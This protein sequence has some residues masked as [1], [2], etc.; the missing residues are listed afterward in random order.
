MKT[1]TV[2]LLLSCI[3]ILFGVSSSNGQEA[4]AL[5]EKNGF[6]DIQLTSEVSQYD[7]LTFKKK[8]SD[9][10]FPDAQL[11]TAKAGHYQEV[12]GIRIQK[13]EVKVYTG[14][15]YE[16]VVIADKDPNFYN[17]LERKYG[18]GKYSVKNN[19]YNWS[20]KNISLT[21][22]SLSKSKVILTYFSHI[23]KKKVK[24]DQKKKVKDIA[25]DF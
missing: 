20:G 7:G 15:I 6:Q 19:S 24:E 23:V 1:A 10:A 2:T 14:L 8:L 17:G 9:K 11:F 16:I 21:F 25:D 22:K 12:G 4:N 13:L 18:K 5:D 3:F